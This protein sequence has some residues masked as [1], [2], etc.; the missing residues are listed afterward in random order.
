MEFSTGALG[1]LIPKL[2]ALLQEEHNLQK[3]VSGRIKYLMA[4]LESIQG[5]LDKVSSAPRF[6]LDKKVM[7]WARYVQEM[8]YDIDDSVDNILV[9]VEGMDPAK[10]HTNIT[11][12]IDRSLD[13]LSKARIRAKLLSK[14]QIRHETALE[15]MDILGCVNKEV[16]QRCD[17]YNVDSIFFRPAAEFI[18]PLNAGQYRKATALVGINETRDKLI[19]VLSV[20]GDVPDRSFKT[21]SVFGSGGLGKTTLARKVYE[22]LRVEFDCCAFVSV[23][24]NPGINK[25][26]EDVLFELDQKKYGN[27]YKTA[28]DEKQLIDLLRRFLENKRYAH[29]KHMS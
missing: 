19:Q 13:M 20:T 5:D 3:S 8:S 12:F 18:D 16:K 2:R 6:K 7:D 29:H 26:F 15:L 28:R 4:E 1:V 9:Q 14:V 23:G 27:I 25:I 11:R 24:K 10:K 22:K 21:V 17:R